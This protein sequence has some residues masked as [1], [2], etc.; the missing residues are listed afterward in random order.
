MEVNCSFNL[1]NGEN[2]FNKLS[3]PHLVNVPRH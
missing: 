2:K 1:F 3:T